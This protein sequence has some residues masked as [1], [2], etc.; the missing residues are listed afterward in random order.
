MTLSVNESRGWA[1]HDACVESKNRWLTMKLAA[2][3]CKCDLVQ[4]KFSEFSR[5][6][7]K[8]LQNNFINPHLT[9]NNII[10]S[11][12][13]FFSEF[14]RSFSIT[15]QDISYQTWLFSLSSGTYPQRLVT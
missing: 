4:H 6:R 9:S 5:I 3:L 10:S 14:Q 2:N 11:I 12:C 13:V 8:I 1:E 7:L 15:C